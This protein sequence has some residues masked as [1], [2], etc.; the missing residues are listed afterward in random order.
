MAVRARPHVS[1]EEFN[2]DEVV[3]RIRAVPDD[4][5]QGA[6]LAREV[7][8]AVNSIAPSQAAPRPRKGPAR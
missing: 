4:S 8:Q 7:L 3:V 1:L 2:R 6:A 5:A